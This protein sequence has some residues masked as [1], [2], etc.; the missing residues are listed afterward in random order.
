MI[1]TSAPSSVPLEVSYA[2]LMRPS[3][4]LDRSHITTILIPGKLAWKAVGSESLHKY[5]R[6]ESR[7][8][9]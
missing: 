9:C 2:R 7:L 5:T 8:G 6:V 3:R 1:T 4:Y